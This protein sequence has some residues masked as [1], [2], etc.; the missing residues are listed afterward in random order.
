MNNDNFEGNH[1]GSIVNQYDAESWGD[2]LDLHRET[3]IELVNERLAY[4]P[5][6][7][8]DV[9]DWIWRLR[10]RQMSNRGGSSHRE[11]T[12]D[13][14]EEHNHDAN[15]EP[16]EQE[17]G[18]H[19]Q[20]SPCAQAE[21]ENSPPASGYSG[22]ANQPRE[23]DDLES[24]FGSGL[25][26]SNYGYRISFTN[27]QRMYLRKLQATLIKVA[28]SLRFDIEKEQIKSSAL[29]FERTLVKYVQAVRD[30]EYMTQF[31][32]QNQDPF[33]A[34]SEREHD[35]F[36]LHKYMTDAS[37]WPGCD[38]LR[39]L[40]DDAIGTGPWEKSRK[41]RGAKPIGGTRSVKLQKT[42]WSRIGG[43]VVGGIFLVGPMWALVLRRDLFFQLSLTTALVTAFGLLMAW[44]LPTLEAVFTATLAYAAVLMVFVGVMM[45]E[46]DGTSSS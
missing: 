20:E 34:S 3:L 6:P 37:K 26:D 11:F 22:Q 28:I 36:I 5:Q 45:Q 42:L 9:Y 2:A 24:S 4:I 46:L 29:L 18:Q 15:P 43:A 23:T 13:Q 8:Y 31:Y 19:N 38:E 40:Q 12:T 25:I 39:K 17:N 14:R 35:N 7:I 41:G 30:H 16:H 21:R 10:Q 27:M 32:Q 33:I 1:A 44:S